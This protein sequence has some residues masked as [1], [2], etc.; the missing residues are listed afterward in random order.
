MFRASSNLVQL[1]KKRLHNPSR[2]RDH[3]ANERTYLA[4]IRTSLGLMGIGILLARLRYLI[5]N[6]SAGTGHSWLLGLATS[7]LGMMTIIVCTHN[8]FSDQK[9]IDQV[10]Y[11][12]VGKWIMF[13]SSSLL[14][15]GSGL[16][17]TI[18]ILPVLP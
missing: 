9:S 10:S 7:F 2:V 8:Y 13:F 16:I 14:L 18:L 17:Y 4:W 5:P 3:L 1:D 6:F 12:P 11:T 15:I